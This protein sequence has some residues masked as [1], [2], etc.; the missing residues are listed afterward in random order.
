MAGGCSPYTF[1]LGVLHGGPL[2]RSRLEALAA[3][4][5]GG[6]DGLFSMRD[7]EVVLGFLLHSGMVVEEG[8]V[9]R[10]N[11]RDP[12]DQQYARVSWLACRGV[13]DGGGP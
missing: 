12:G 8:G 5:Y 4:V 1:I 10:L 7:F 13:V 3:K 2:P 6:G 11:L 9:L